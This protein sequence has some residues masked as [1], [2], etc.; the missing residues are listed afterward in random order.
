[1]LL[2]LFMKQILRVLLFSILATGFFAARPLPKPTWACTPCGHDCD[3]L[4]FE[5]AGS[6]PHC[7]MPLVDV[8]TLGPADELPSTDIC[9]FIKANP[10]V[11]LLD[12]RS[13][14]EFAGN[15]DPDFGTIR[16]AINIPLPQLSERLDELKQYRDK[17]ILVYCS[18]SHRSHE[19]QYKLRQA[20]FQ[21]VKNLAGG[22]SKVTDVA[23]KRL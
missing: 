9:A 7:M 6:C 23:C 5:K 12:V 3:T 1:M 13:P 4:R 19:A 16:G 21:H 10:N 11:L 15:A 22:M 18:H 17:E 20:G 2:H 8:K 14:E